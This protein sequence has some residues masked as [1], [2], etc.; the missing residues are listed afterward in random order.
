MPRGIFNCFLVTLLLVLGACTTAPTAKQTY[1][2]D[3][4]GEVAFKNFLVIGV[5][6]SYNSRAEFERK[7]ASALRVQGASASPYHTVVPGNDS[8]NRQAVLDAV[9]ANAFD[10]VL[11]TRIV[12]QAADVSVEDTTTS[13]TAS[14]IGGNAVNLFRY[15]YEEL[16][17]PGRLNLELTVILASELFSAAEEKMI[18]AIETSYS[19]APNVGALI[20]VTAEKIVGELGGDGLVSP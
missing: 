13:T 11:V 19:N 14:T 18:W 4:F 7:V 17:E 15:D 16:S 5:A 12:S 9:N 10:A 6:G 3:D 2:D 20:D 8:L 1:F